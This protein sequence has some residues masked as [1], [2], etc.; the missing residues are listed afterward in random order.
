MAWK[1]MTPWPEASEP[2]YLSGLQNILRK[3]LDTALMVSKGLGVEICGFHYPQISVPE[4]G[5]WNCYT[6]DS[7][8]PPYIYS[9]HAKGCSGKHKNFKSLQVTESISESWMHCSYHRIHYLVCS[10]RLLMGHYEYE[11]KE[12]GMDGH[13]AWPS[14]VLLMFILELSL[15]L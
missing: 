10:H 3:Q 15:Y 1:Y 13:F 4:Q 11:I 5:S 8:G 12:T 9:D 7:K 14:R 2:S 6:A